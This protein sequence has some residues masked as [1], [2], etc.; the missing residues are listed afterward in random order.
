MGYAWSLSGHGRTNLVMDAALSTDQRGRKPNIV[1]NPSD[2][3]ATT[4]T[5][6]VEAT[7]NKATSRLCKCAAG[8]LQLEMCSK[9]IAIGHGG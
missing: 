4:S 9:A 1:V 2:S 8:N 7:V 6:V 3:I 5:D